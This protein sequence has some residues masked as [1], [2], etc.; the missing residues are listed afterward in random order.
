MRCILYFRFYRVGKVTG[1][2]DMY[3]HEKTTTVCQRSLFYTYTY[4]LLL[5][6]LYIRDYHSTGHK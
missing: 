3:V 4:F 5:L 2:I 1:K 6:F